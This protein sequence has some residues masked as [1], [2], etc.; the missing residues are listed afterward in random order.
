[1]QPV[2]GHNDWTGL[3]KNWVPFEYDGALVIIYQCCPTHRVSGLETVW[4][5]SGPRWPYGEI[6][7]GTP[8]VEYEGNWLRFFHSH[9]QNELNPP[10]HRYYV[11]AY[12]MEPA[13]PFK[14]VRV[15][16]KP[17]LYGSEADDL[18]PEQRK[19]CPH[20]KRN[21]VFPGGIVT[22][23]DGWLLSVG[24]NDSACAIVKIK[25]ESLNL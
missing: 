18:T 13:P 11:G 4:E 25:P 3:E 2:F 19:S 15:S 6:R 14:V 24:V 20:W 12:L 5:T 9:L 21:V 22:K 10:H 8:P 17:V 23:L 7:G 16:R 1:V